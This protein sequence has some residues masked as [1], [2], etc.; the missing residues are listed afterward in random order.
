MVRAQLLVSMARILSSYIII[1]SSMTSQP[2]WW[3]PHQCSWAGIK[4]AIIW[5]HQTTVT[6]TNPV[7]PLKGIIKIICLEL[8]CFLN[9]TKTTLCYSHIQDSRKWDA[10][11]PVQWLRVN[12]KIELIEEFEINKVYLKK[13]GVL[14]K[15]LAIFTLCILYRS[16]GY[17]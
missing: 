7:V 2:G 14:W 1:V 12:S 13:C 11:I 10:L 9:Q 16:L 15:C 17:M 6:P 3:P 4:P 5:L 8:F